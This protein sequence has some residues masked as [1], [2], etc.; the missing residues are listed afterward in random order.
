M[1]DPIRYDFMAD[2]GTELREERKWCQMCLDRKRK[3]W[4]EK[5]V[6]WWSE[7]VELLHL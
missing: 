1:T 3:A 4:K 2:W 7:L 5:R 6:D